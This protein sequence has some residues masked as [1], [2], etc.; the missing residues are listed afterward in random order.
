MK[1]G[2]KDRSETDSFVAFVSSN[3]VRTEW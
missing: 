3:F 1:D 2:N